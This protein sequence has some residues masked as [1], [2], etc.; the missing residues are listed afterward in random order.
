MIIEGVGHTWGVATAIN[1]GLQALFKEYFPPDSSINGGFNSIQ[2][3]YRELSVVWGYTV[4]IPRQVVASAALDMWQ[5]GEKEKAIQCLKEEIEI[6]L[7]DSISFY[8][9]GKMLLKT[10]DLDGALSAANSGLKAEMNK[11]VP[12]G[13][14]L[15][16][17]NSLI[18]TISQV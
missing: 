1:F 10:G 12:N 17:F 8:Y 2:D 18:S 7:Y 5:R 15:N 11:S 13:V 16:E 9:P 14:N 6:D 3:Y 4:N